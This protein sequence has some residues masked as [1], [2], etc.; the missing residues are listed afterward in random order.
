MTTPETHP[1]VDGGDGARTSRRTFLQFASATVGAGLSTTA[2]SG[3]RAT[4]G[5]EI[6]IATS[7]AHRSVSRAAVGAI[8]DEH[9]S[10]D[11]SIQSAPTTVGARRFTDGAADALVGSR[12]LLPAERGRAADNGVAFECREHPTAMAAIRHPASTW[13]D[14][15][16][17]RQVAATWSGDSPVETWAEVSLA[18]L[19]SG[20]S[21]DSAALPSETPADGRTALVRG[22]RAYQYA[23]GHGGP[24]VYEP[25]R[26]WLVAD[27]P[28]DG[29]GYTPLV[30]L[31]SLYVDSEA[32]TREPVA[33]FVR[34]F[35]RRSTDRA[36]GV[37][38]V[39]GPRWST[40][41]TT[42]GEGRRPPRP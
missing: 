38:Y 28:T 22:V 4:A 29:D 14:C 10:T 6:R 26:R 39:T 30:R 27:P 13:I 41:D 34:Q 42:S 5:F 8:R 16:R 21:G 12:P 20:G 25:H 18:E 1:S 2:A 37:E 31:A 7:P 32:L 15:L 35:A 33:D 23:E 19:G 36:G 17:P 3:R 9:P 11:L 24:G 40:E